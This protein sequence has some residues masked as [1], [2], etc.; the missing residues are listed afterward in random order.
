M[1]GAATGMGFGWSFCGFFLAAGAWLL[2]YFLWARQA[3][4]RDRGGDDG[5]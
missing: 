1:E 2:I 4:R 5:R 3:A